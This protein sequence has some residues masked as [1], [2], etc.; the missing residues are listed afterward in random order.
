M[1]A[2]GYY[3][4]NAAAA[5]VIDPPPDPNPNPILVGRLVKPV[6]RLL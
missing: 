6:K 3:Y 4:K 5:R 1:I 2:W